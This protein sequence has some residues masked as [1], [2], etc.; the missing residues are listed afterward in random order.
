MPE[1]QLGEQN[2][3]IAKETFLILSVFGEDSH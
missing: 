3:N 1:Y 2:E